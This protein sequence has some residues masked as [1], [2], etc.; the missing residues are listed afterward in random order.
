M[1]FLNILVI[2][3][4]ILGVIIGAGF[5]SGQ[6]IKFFFTNYGI[7]GLVEM[8]L[9]VFIICIVVNLVLRILLKYKLNS[10]NEFLEKTF[11][12]KPVL[13]YSTRN[14]IYFFLLASFLIMSIGFSTCLEQQFGINRYIGA[15]I[16]SIL[17]YVAFV[18]SVDR[19]L[20]INKYIMPVLVIL[21]IVVGVDTFINQNLEISQVNS[22][23]MFLVNSFIYASYNVIPLIPLL[24]TLKM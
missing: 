17:C 6:E 22:N 19:I 3:T 21:I 11:Y 24:A 18:G 14:I 13:I 5:A 12:K 9:A 1:K 15:L 7:T 16:L 2:V 23:Y 4:L 20:K 8:L 10:Y